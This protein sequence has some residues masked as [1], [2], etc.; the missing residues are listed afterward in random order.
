MLTYMYNGNI[1]TSY[2]GNNYSDYDGVDDNGDGIGDTPRYEDSYPL[3]FWPVIPLDPIVEPSDAI[4]E[5]KLS[6]NELE[7]SPGINESINV[8]L[9][10]VLKQLEKGDEYKAIKKL[11][12]LMLF[13]GK[14]PP[15]TLDPNSANFLIAEA[16]KI[17]DMIEL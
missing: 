17:I 2:I 9:D 8:R 11:E 10:N 3:M 15:Q 7:L 13:I 12:D 6:I 4:E 14:L 5:L 1:F 16:Q